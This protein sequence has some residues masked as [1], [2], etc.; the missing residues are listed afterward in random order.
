[1]SGNYPLDPRGKMDIELLITEVFLTPSIW[2][3]SDK[4]HSDRNVIVHQ[5]KRIA[6]KLGVAGKF[7]LAKLYCV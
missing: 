3:A 4:Q 7:I 5:W 1:M 6:E 2:D